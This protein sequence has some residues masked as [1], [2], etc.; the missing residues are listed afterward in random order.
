MKTTFKMTFSL[1]MT[2]G[3]SWLW[4]QAIKAIT[5]GW[6]TLKTCKGLRK[7]TDGGMCSV[8]LKK[9]FKSDFQEEKSLQAPHQSDQSGLQLNAKATCVINL[10]SRFQMRGRGGTNDSSPGASAALEQSSLDAIWAARWEEQPQWGLSPRCPYGT[11]SSSSSLT[12]FSISRDAE[13]MP[14]SPLRWSNSWI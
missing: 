5:K 10:R 1:F 7:S 6:E 13:A 3:E 8:R 9:L 14:P 12:N 11:W 2:L 4:K